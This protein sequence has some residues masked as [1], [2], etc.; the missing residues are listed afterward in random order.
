MTTRHLI[1]AA[2]ITVTVD[3][4]S[5][6]PA[7]P[8]NKPATA[9]KQ[10]I[11]AR[12]KDDDGV[13]SL[14][15]FPGKNKRLFERI[16][17]N[18]DGKVSLAEDT[19]F[20]RS[21]IADRRAV[22]RRAADRRTEFVGDVKVERDLVYARVGERE[23]RLDL[24]LP[25]GDARQDEK[26]S[27]VIVRIHGGGWKG[28]RKGNGGRARGV[29]QRGYALVDVEYRLSGEAIFPAQVQDCKA[30]IRWVRANSKR[31]GLDPDR[32]GVIGSSAGGHLAAFLGTTA[33]TNEFDTESHGDHSSRVQ[34]V[35]DLWGP[36][37]LLQ[38]DDHRIPGSM[39]VHNA[40]NSPESLLV[41]GPIQSEPFRALAVRANPIAYVR[42]QK[43]PP[44][45]IVH[46]DRDLSV[47]PHQSELLHAALSAN[48]TDTTL[49]LVKNGGHGL[50]GGDVK[51]DDLLK[52]VLT[53]FDKHL[54]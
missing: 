34:A 2:L 36:T 22:D 8:G 19:A 37:D 28:G 49:Q 41:G 31:F 40:E 11:E 13:L 39:L 43:L 29:E 23:L 51:N 24:Y 25:T 17:T 52:L 50:R 4:D 42:G 54:K 35:C 32:I 38:M 33:E 9:A 1:L 53:F 48:G 18:G 27:P 30:A 15:E 20:R 10:F 26:P 45:L 16:D 5:Q 44:F 14:D 3:A 7:V 47:P 46:G 21:R 12:D 6:S